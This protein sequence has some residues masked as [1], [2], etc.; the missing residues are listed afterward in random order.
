[1]FDDAGVPLT[2]TYRE[3]RALAALARQL[4][5]EDPELAVELSWPA[6]RVG[7][8][9]GDRI[10][11]AMLWIGL[12]FLL[13]ALVLAEHLLATLGFLLLITSWFPMQVS[14]L[15]EM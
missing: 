2:L 5:T 12:S 7:L 13:A 9:V 4:T 1:M 3:R 11:W 10:A 8:P 15:N 14:R 6:A